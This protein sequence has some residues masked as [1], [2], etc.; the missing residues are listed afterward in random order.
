SYSDE[1]AINI[2]LT[3]GNGGNEYSWDQSNGGYGVEYSTEDQNSLKIG[4][5]SVSVSDSKSCTADTSINITGPTEITFGASAVTDYNGVGDEGA[6]NLEIAGGTGTPS[7]YS[8]NWTGPDSYTA[9]TQD[10]TNLEAGAYYVTATDNNL[11]TAD[12]LFNVINID[13]F[14]AYISSKKNACKGTA[15]G[16][17]TVSYYSPVGNTDMSYQWDANAGNQTSATANNLAGGNYYKV[18]VTDNNTSYESVDSV[19]IEEL[20]YDFA[21]SLSGTTDLN[22][23][24]D[25]DG[26]VDLTINTNGELPYTYLWNTGNETQDIS[27]LSAGNYNVTVVDDNECQ[28]I[29]PIHTISEPEF[30]ITAEISILSEPL[31]FGDLNG[32]LRVDVSGG[33]KTYNYQWDDPAFQTTQVADGLDAGYYNVIVEDYKGCSASDGINLTQPDVISINETI[34]DVNCFNG[35]DGT[36]Q[37][38]INGGTPEFDYFWETSDGAGLVVTDKNQSQLEAGNYSLTATDAHNCFLT[39]SY[40]ISQPSTAIEITFEDKTDIANCFGD[41][42]G[43]ITVD[44]IGGTGNLTYTLNPEASETNET[45]EFADLIAGNYTVD[46]TD[47]NACGPLTSSELNI[48][49]PNEITITV[50]DST[51]LD[52]YGT[53]AGTIL[54]NI[55]GGTVA[56]DYV[57]NWE[58][59]NGDGLVVTEQN[60]TGLSGGTYTVTVTD[61]N[62]CEKVRNVSLTEPEELLIDSIIISNASARIKA[63][64]SI[65]IYASGGT[66]LYTYTI[67][68]DNVSNQTGVFENVPVGSYTIEVN[69]ANMCGPV[70]EEI[71]ITGIM[72]EFTRDR[73][74]KIYPNPANDNLFIEINNNIN[75]SYNV[76]II[77]IS[78]QVIKNFNSVVNK[79]E[80]DISSISKGIYFV[81]LNS[82]GLIDKQ[83][84]II[85]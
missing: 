62:N 32:E 85:R 56:S 37:L 9:S 20:T 81:K 52:C 45:G 23:K 51:N 53:N 64:G 29:T 72:E 36:I 77:N 41:N 27:G 47:E 79:Q 10:I 83:K 50:A 74:V 68:P 84:L 58:T 55:L 31:C 5:Y 22:C 78:G 65:T 3:G 73:L 43:A 42:T 7:A 19:L 11:C 70:S 17:A 15:D 46:V 30:A 59:S 76:Q 49:Q 28:F 2:N 6:I 60:Q 38:E 67:L 33:N 80:I 69:D 25:N 12:T 71:A 44:A 40:L 39:K 8:A 13:V 24:G 82:D 26:Y 54:L 4:T 21:G 1:G 18:T 66:E 57:F 14:Y 34:S 48:S 16:R 35:K 75:E 63:D 61:D